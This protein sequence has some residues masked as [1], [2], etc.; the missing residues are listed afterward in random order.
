MFAALE[1]ANIVMTVATFTGFHPEIG[2]GHLESGLTISPVQ[3]L[4]ER[5]L[6]A[7]LKFLERRVIDEASLG[8]EALE[9]VG[10]GLDRNFV[11]QDHTLAHFRRECW[12]PA[13]YGRNGWTPEDDQAVKDKALKKVK[14]LVAAHRKPAGRDDQ[15]AKA[16]AVVERARR[17]LGADGVS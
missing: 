3:L 10:F 7:S 17:E 5:E 11:E 9:D 13:F 15:I 1:K 12:L 2:L 16:K 14:E 4:I 6:T 8:L